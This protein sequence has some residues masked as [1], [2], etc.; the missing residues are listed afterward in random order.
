ME[1]LKDFIDRYF[2]EYAM[3][4]QPDNASKRKTDSSTDTDGLTLTDLSS[5]ESINKALE[6]LGFLHEKI[7]DLK[8]SFEL[9]RQR[10]C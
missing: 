9:T 1:G 10:K 7:K 5:L 3:Q 2:Y 8:V 6:V 4:A